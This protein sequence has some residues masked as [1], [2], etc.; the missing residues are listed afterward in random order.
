MPQ[1]TYKIVIGGYDLVT[2]ELSF[3]DETGAYDAAT[4]PG[5]YGAPNDERAAVG[6]FLVS[7]RRESLRRVTLPQAE[8][9][10]LTADKFY[11][12]PGPDGWVQTNAY[13]VP[14]GDATLA[15]PPAPALPVPIVIPAGPAPALTPLYPVAPVAF[16]PEYVPTDLFIYDATAAQLYQ[17][18]CYLDESEQ[19]ISE[20]V[21]VAGETLLGSP[22]LV[23]TI[24]QLV[25]DAFVRLR[26]KLCQ[27]CILLEFDLVPDQFNE[28]QGDAVRRA[29]ARVKLLLEGAAYQWRLGNYYAAQLNLETIAGLNADQLL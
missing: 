15:P 24:N 9:D 13:A 20:W 1:P 11:F 6:I 23:S 18:Q 10:P 26:A 2:K 21:A 22:Y 4:N 3:S 27:A 29:F 5:G 7:Q 14:L 12:R 16:V 25:V 8:A 17:R 28:P 19:T